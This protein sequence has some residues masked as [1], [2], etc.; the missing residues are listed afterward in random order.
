MYSPSRANLFRQGRP[1]LLVAWVCSVTLALLQCIVSPAVAAEADLRIVRIGTG[2]TGGT[3][4]PMG[5][6]IA[7]A[8]SDSRRSE[9]GRSEPPAV[10]LLMVAQ[11][12]NGSVN[13][14]RELRKGNLDAALVQADVAHWAYQGS[15]VFSGEPRYE[16][17]RA[18]AHLYPESLH[19]VV[20]KGSGIVSVADLRGRRVSLDEPGS[21]TVLD[22]RIILD[23]YEMKESDLDAVYLKP[24]FAAQEMAQ[25]QLDAFFIIA[26]YPVT[27]VLEL[28]ASTGAHLVPI[29][30]APIDAILQAHPYFERGVIPAGTYDRG[31]IPAGTYKGI[32]DT[33]TLNVGAQL[34]VDEHLDEDLVYRLTQALWSERTLR[35]LEQGHP[36]GREIRPER[37][38]DGISIPLH[39]GA[40]RYYRESGL[41]PNTAGED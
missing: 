31:I 22:A 16:H 25:N 17:L 7:Q 13:N 5:S 20:R 15:V 38:L 26:G 1:P 14:V 40:K 41:L 10:E 27:A 3:Y 39:P 36:K 33:P 32:S 34:V 18:V 23:H 8:L 24:Y 35:I 30:G 9:R 19:L 4:F 21:G 37:A 6:L 2:G 29:E 11:I 12:S 28:A